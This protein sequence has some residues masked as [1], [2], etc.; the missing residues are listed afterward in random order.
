MKL[1][2]ATIK[3]IKYKKEGK[4][5]KIEQIKNRPSGAEKGEPMSDKDAVRWYEH[6]KEKDLKRQYR[7]E[8]I[9][10]LCIK[11]SLIS[12]LLAVLFVAA[13][14]TLTILGLLQQ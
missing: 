10:D 14:L 9:M 12:S 8:K 4:A 11:I 5:L 6:E 1:R 13:A 3:V 2:R 7:R